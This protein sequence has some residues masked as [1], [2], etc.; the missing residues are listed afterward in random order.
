M[1]S[2]SNLITNPGAQGYT[3][4]QKKKEEVQLTVLR[5][6]SE[7]RPALSLSFHVVQP[8]EHAHEGLPLHEPLTL[9]LV[10]S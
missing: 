10:L 9:S 5:R 3:V 8:I 4:G 2:H 6:R 7:N 1:T